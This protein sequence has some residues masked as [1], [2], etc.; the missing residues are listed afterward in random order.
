[1]A[2]DPGIE[3]GYCFAQLD[4]NGKVHYK[5][6]QATD[7]VAELWDRLNNTKPRYI[8]MESFDFRNAPK[9]HTKVELFPRE[10]I[11]VARLYS[12][13]ADHDCAIYLQSPSQGKG[14]YT[15]SVLKGKG[16]Y[17]PAHP[18]AMDA[19]RHLLQWLTFGA[20]Y[21][22]IEGVEDPFVMI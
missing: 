3:T 17:K 11:G 14:Y 15:D 22:L 7:D 9:R 21:K 19:S 2:I 5:P 12:L 4:D 8:I 18:H 16:L 10:L 20:G 1:M 6:F 13:V